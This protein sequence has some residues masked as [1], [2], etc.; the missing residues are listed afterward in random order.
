MLKVGVERVKRLIFK[1][2]STDYRCFFLAHIIIKCLKVKFP[3]FTRRNINI[4][5]FHDILFI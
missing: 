5:F 3:L 2:V 4:Y 1:T